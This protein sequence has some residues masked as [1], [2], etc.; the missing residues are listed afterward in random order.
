MNILVINDDTEKSYHYAYIKNLTRLLS[1]K[2]SRHC[3]KICNI[4]LKRFS[5]QK[6]LES[7]NHKFN[8]NDSNIDLPANMHIKDNKL[9]KLLINSYVKP[10]NIKH[11]L[12]LPWVMYCDF[13]SIL[14]PV[15][16][17]SKFKDKYEHEL[18]SYYYNL[19]CRER[20]SFNK[21][22][23]YRSK[24]EYD[25]VIDKFFHDVKDILIDILQCKKNIMRYQ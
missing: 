9:L 17:D 23:I 11:N 12:T 16:D 13:E 4:C 7:S 20:P 5:S 18:R 6:A 25:N 24:D 21:F 8:Y 1:A 10:Y 3:N 15:S 2:S 14:T 22:K 19:V